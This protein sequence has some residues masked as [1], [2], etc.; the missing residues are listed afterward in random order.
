MTECLHRRHYDEQSNNR[1]LVLPRSWR[2]ASCHLWLLLFD[3]LH[4]FFNYQLE[5]LF[6]VFLLL[7]FFYSFGDFVIP[8]G[9]EYQIKERG[10]VGMVHSATNNENWYEGEKTPD[11]IWPYSYHWAQ[12]SEFSCEVERGRFCKVWGSRTSGPCGRVE[13]EELFGRH[14]RRNWRPEYQRS[15]SGN[16]QE[17]RMQR[18]MQ[19]LFIDVMYPW[20]DRHGSNHGN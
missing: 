15:W 16:G 8:S 17:E 20:S 4:L 18:R 12:A 6:F 14:E 1:T 10:M 5:K 7:L 11:L 19:L 2:C 3:L 13:S 9:C